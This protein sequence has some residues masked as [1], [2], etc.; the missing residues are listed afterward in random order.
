[1]N[2]QILIKKLI[3]CLLNDFRFKLT[4]N[5][6]AIARI[7]YSLI[8]APTYSLNCNHKN[9]K[10]EPEESNQMLTIDLKWTEDKLFS[11][12]DD[13]LC[14]INT[15]IEFVSRWILNHIKIDI[16]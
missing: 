9:L 4:N 13:I 6:H 7:I 14:T 15:S 10:I 5:E 1:M 12:S 8:S 16:I 3:R 2:G 11:N